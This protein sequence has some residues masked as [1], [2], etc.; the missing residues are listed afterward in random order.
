MHTLNRP[1]GGAGAQARSQ[2]FGL[3][4]A[5][6][7]EGG[8]GTGAIDTSFNN[9]AFNYGAETGFRQLDQGLGLAVQPEGKVIV[10]GSASNEAGI[11]RVDTNGSLDGGF[12]NGGT[13]VDTARPGAEAGRLSRQTFGS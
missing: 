11:A 6:F 7:V 13:I 10:V 3:R 4:V 9:P 8:Q 5:E 12:G 1:A 2:V